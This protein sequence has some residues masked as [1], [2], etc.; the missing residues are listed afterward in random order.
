MGMECRWDRSVAEGG[1]D[2]GGREAYF[3]KRHVSRATE[4]EVMDGA[5]PL[6]GFLAR[7]LSSRHEH[8]RL[9]FPYLAWQAA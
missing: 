5:E 7:M 8:N 1:R 6:Q 3:D 9:R 2:G 4:Q